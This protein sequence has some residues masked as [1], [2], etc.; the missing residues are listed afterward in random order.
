MSQEPPHRERN[1][2]TGS[3]EN[4]EGNLLFLMSVWPSRLAGW[5]AYW[6]R[7]WLVGSQTGRL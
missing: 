5:F 2:E 4:E 6:Q 3:M 1:A 7:G